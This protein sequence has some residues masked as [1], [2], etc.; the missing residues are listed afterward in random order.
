MAVKDDAVALEFEDWNG[1]RHLVKHKI[2]IVNAREESYVY[3]T[4]EHSYICT[5]SDEP[6][7]DGTR[8]PIAS[9]L[10]VQL[11][12]FFKTPI[13][14]K[15]RGVYFDIVVPGFQSQSKVDDETLSTTNPK[16]WEQYGHASSFV[17]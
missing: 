12:A 7:A 3:C 6:A 15:V 2:V 16:V 9:D 10:Y 5:E 1:K 14:I 11:L 13:W 17:I 8:K 4:H